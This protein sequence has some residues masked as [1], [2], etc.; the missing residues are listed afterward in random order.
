MNF[1]KVTFKAAKTIVDLV[2]V[3]S[4]LIAGLYACY[5]LWDN[6]RVYVKADNVQ[7]DM[8]KYKP[9]LSK[10]DGRK[11]IKKSFAELR[12]INPD[13]CAWLT[14]NNTRI[15]Y[16]VLQGK[17]NLSYINTDVYGDFTLAG[18]IFLDSRCSNDFSDD[19]SIIYGH[20]I[21]NGRM[22]GDLDKF[23]EKAFFDKN[24]T[25]NLI[26][27][28]KTFK[29]EIFSVFTVGDS[30]ETLFTPEKNADLSI[31]YRYSDSKALY[32]DGSVAGKLLSPQGNA[33]VLS[34]STCSSEFTD[35]RTVVLA[36]MVPQK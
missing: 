7:E 31:I 34:L 19:Y 27:P 22:F 12:A 28:E 24:K 23:K 18:S 16:P 36:L 15:D 33:Q 2:I 5:A 35:A 1:S 29:L 30:D 8:L 13:V 14:V 25:G 10:N 11:S 9:D 6:Y 21:A 20:H 32:Y 17:D 3:I 4:L 26:T